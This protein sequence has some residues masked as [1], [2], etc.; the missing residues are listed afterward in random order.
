MRR[1]VP[2]H[3]FCARMHSGAVLLAL[4]E[5]SRGFHIDPAF[6]PSLYST[7]N[8]AIASLNNA[9][10]TS[11]RNTM[12]LSAVI[13]DD[14]QLARDELAYL[15]KNLG[16]EPVFSD[17]QVTNRQSKST[18]RVAIRGAGILPASRVS[19]APACGPD[20]RTIE[21]ALGGRPDDTAKMVWSRG[22]I[23][24][25]LQGP[26]AKPTKICAG[27]GLTHPRPVGHRPRPGSRIQV[28]DAALSSGAAACLNNTLEQR[29]RTYHEQ[30]YR[31]AARA[32]FGPGT[33]KGRLRSRED[34][35]S[36]PASQLRYSSTRRIPSCSWCCA[37]CRA[38]SRSR[39][40]CPSD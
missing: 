22:C 10:A 32:R 36:K 6:S 37:A 1:E 17:F 8:M 5:L 2:A 23:A 31:L 15:L 25:L 24:Y 19:A 26:L 4:P 35:P 27:A 7:K 38:G 12:P 20:T 13:V 29:S 11:A 3:C 40:W 39:P 16:D 33:K 21:I 18:Y 14:E 30:T 28:R 34:A 9:S